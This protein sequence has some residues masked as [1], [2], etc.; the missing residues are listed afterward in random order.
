[1][2]RIIKALV[3]F[4][5]IAVPLIIVAAGAG[6]LWL[7]RSLPPSSGTMK[8]SGLSDAVTIARDQNGVPHIS[9]ATIEDVFAGL[10]FVHAQDRQ[11]Q[12]EVVRVAAQGRLSELFG[13]PT[14]DSDIWLRSMGFYE[15]SK[16]SYALLPDEAKRAVDAYTLGINAWMTRESRSFAS[17]LPPE[18]VILNH[19]PEPWEPAHTLSVLRMMSVTLGKNAAEEVQRLAFARLGFSTRDIYELMPLLPGETPPALPDLTELLEL[20][21]GPLQ[22]S[23]AGADSRDHSWR[24]GIRTKRER[25]TTG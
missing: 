15:A 22:V 10:G 6:Y 14:V 20:N 17:R 25:R 4:I 18:F 5:F 1:M 19:T 13:E 16:A 23:D 24:S 11:W 2:R 12:M 21:T 9:G 3:R 8:L 7:A